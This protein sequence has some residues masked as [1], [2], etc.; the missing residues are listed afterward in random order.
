MTT[1]LATS[2][3]STVF[4][5][6]ELPVAK[7][8]EMKDVVRPA[9]DPVS[10]QSLKNRKCYVRY[11]I[12]FLKTICFPL[13]LL[14]VVQAAGPAS[15]LRDC[16]FSRGQF[17]QKLCP[18][19]WKPF[20]KTKYSRPAQCPPF[21]SLG[22][23]IPQANCVSYVL[24]LFFRQNVPSSITGA[25]MLVESTQTV[26]QYPIIAFDFK[27]SQADLI[28]SNNKRLPKLLTMLR[29]TWIYTLAECIVIVRIHSSPCLLFIRADLRHERFSS[30]FCCSDRP[31][32]RG[33][34]ERERDHSLH[35]DC[36]DDIF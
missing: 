26:P 4:Q 35:S 23:S 3:Q 24:Y 22:K 1:F 15:A 33:K 14:D 34:L 21:Q 32:G 25:E 31:A 17:S 30:L 29:L 20:S 28:Y 18:W 27:F 12:L 11:S 9:A 19:K 6:L 5:R 13:V 36:P 7:P 2:A 10:V 16:R 8:L